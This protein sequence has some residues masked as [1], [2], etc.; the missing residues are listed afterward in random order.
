M[1]LL[2]QSGRWKFIPPL[3]VSETNATTAESTELDL[4]E[5]AKTF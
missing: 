5:G 1:R 2:Q 4:A 3:T